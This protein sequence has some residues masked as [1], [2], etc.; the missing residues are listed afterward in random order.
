MTSTHKNKPGERGQ[1]VVEMVL[2][3]VVMAGVTIFV[4]KTFRDN[5]FIAKLVSGPWESLSGLIQNGVWGRPGE[6]MSKHP[7]VLGRLNTV[8]GEDLK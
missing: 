3:L 8:R 7:N 5:D 1:M 6:T 4:T 2:M